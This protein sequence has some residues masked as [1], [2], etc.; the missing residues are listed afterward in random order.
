MATLDGKLIALS[1]PYSRRGA[2][3]ETYKRHHGKPGPVLVAKAPTQTMNPGIPERI[4]N[5]ALERDPAAAQA[6]YFAEFRADLEQFITRETVER[7]M[8]TSPLELPYIRGTKYQ[9]FADPSGG[10]PDGFCLSIGHTEGNKI[11]IDVVRER[12]GPPASAVTEYASLLKD[13]GIRGVQGDRYG[14][15]WPEQEFARH[16]INY[17]PCKRSKSDLYVDALAALNSERV[18]LPPD[19]KMLNQFIGLERRTSRAGKDSIDHAPGGHD[20]L[21][22]ACAGLIAQHQKRKRPVAV[23]GTYG[24][25]DDPHDGI[26]RGY[27]MN[28]RY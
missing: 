23:F 13:S 24:T 6:E 22:N 19:D 17:L 15:S 5:E 3:W 14:G 11:I 9:A 18:E 4:I 20:D 12:K 26:K 1:S 10:G 21:A 2:L 25:S 16:G 7:A 28:E 27:R 8:R